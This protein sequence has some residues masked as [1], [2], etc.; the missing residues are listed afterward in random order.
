MKKEKVQERIIRVASDLFYRQGFNSTGINQIIAE[1]DIA[2]GSLYNHFTSKNDLLQAY[3]IKEETEWFKGFEEHSAKISEPKQK[4]LS[5]LDYRK[6]LQKSSKFGGCHFIKISAEVGDSSPVVSDFVKKHK[7]K[8]K[9][10]IRTLV[11]GYAES[12]KEFDA[13]LT[14]ESI[15]LLIEGA[16]V[17]ST[18]NK[19]ADSFDQIQKMIEVQLP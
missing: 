8:Q 2:I 18:I 5:L 9:E 17:S 6:K 7:G 14:T 3:L 16:V 11:N 12:K 13:D 15:F 19:N 10:M 4:I 1:A